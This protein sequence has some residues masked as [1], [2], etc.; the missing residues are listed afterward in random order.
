MHGPN[1]NCKQHLYFAGKLPCLKSIWTNKHKKRMHNKNSTTIMQPIT[2]SLQKSNKHFSLLPP[3]VRIQPAS[4]LNT[5]RSQNE[6]MTL[7]RKWAEIM[8]FLRKTLW[9][10]HCRA[11]L[12]NE[13]ERTAKRRIK[14]IKHTMLNIPA[15]TL[16]W[17]LPKNLN[18]V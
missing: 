17:P 7:L 5:I 14:N 18:Q 1:E 10:T 8:S 2:Y 13:R 12:E 6:S 4:H 11:C 16:T 15:G 3:M 9:E